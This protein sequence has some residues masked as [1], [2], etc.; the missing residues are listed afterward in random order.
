[1]LE[2]YK[3]FLNKMEKLNLYLVNFNKNSIIKD[4]T[5]PSEC[6]IRDKNCWLISIITYNK[7]MF[8]ANNGICK[9]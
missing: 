9:V 4:K 5:Y 7:Y 3:K 6:I 8:L 1:M 2:D